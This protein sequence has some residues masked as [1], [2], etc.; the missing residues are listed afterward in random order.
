MAVSI[1][2]IIISFLAIIFAAVAAFFCIKI[3]KYVYPYLFW[4]AIYVPTTR[5]RVEKMVEFLETKPG[6]LAV[7][8]GAGDG[9]LVIALA[10]A[11]AVAQGYE[12]NPFL[13]S[14]A[15]ENI[16]KAGLEGKAFVYYKNLWRQD[17]KNFDAVV[18]F[19]MSHMMRKLENKFEKE[20]K[21]GARIVSNYFALPTW[22]PEKQE[23]NIY[24]YIK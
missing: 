13:V 3:F 11:G 16:K 1:I 22:Q 9:R 23:E 17:L 24:L 6:Q 18:V 5:E 21:P 10:N 4:G 8:L 12:I 19:P 14:L 7:D 20:L 2:F 15:T